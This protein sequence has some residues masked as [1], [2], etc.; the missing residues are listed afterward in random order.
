MEDSFDSPEA[1]QLFQAITSLKTLEDTKKFIRDLC[2]IT[3]IKSMIERLEIARRVR[4]KEPYRMIS[5]KTGCSSATITR[6]AHWVHYGEK[7]YINTLETLEKKGF[8][9][10]ES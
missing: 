7:G 4:N 3:E 5:E 10:Q 8:L 6:V 2:T 9:I 1:H